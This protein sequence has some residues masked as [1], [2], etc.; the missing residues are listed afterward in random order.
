[1]FFCLISKLIISNV[2]AWIKS[3]HFGLLKMDTAKRN[4]KIRRSKKKRLIFY[5][6]F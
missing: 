2:D 1:M 3:E 5:Q 6:K 4:Q